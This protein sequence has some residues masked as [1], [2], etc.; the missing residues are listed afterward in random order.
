MQ[1]FH[2]HNLKHLLSKCSVISTGLPFLPRSR[3]TSRPRRRL[4]KP[5]LSRLSRRPC[6]LSEL[7]FRN[8][9]RWMG[10]PAL[11]ERRWSSLYMTHSAA[12]RSGRSQKHTRT[13][14]SCP[15]SH[16]PRTQLYSKSRCSTVCRWGTPAGPQQNQPRCSC[17]SVAGLPQN[18]FDA[19]PN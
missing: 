9:H 1:W 3:A 18:S 8:S 16:S 14:E 10:S 13:A 5:L 2:I 4:P 6:W 11:L 7:I 17:K 19:E 12:D 15:K